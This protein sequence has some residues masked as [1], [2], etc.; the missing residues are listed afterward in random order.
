[1]K[2]FKKLVSVVCAA[3]VLT[4]SI[5]FT[6]SAFS[7]A[8]VSLIAPLITFG[9]GDSSDDDT[10]FAGRRGADALAWYRRAMA[11]LYM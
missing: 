9:Q 3:T 7:A 5:A 6:T 1:M 4:S 11:E 2:M 8:S 10:Y